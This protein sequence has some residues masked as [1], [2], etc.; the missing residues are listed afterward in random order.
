[1]IRQ[2]ISDTSRFA[3]FALSVVVIVAGYAWM[4]HRAHVQNPKNKTLPNLSQFVE[5]WQRMATGKGGI[6]FVGDVRASA[7][8]LALGVGSGVLLAFVV[9]L[10]MGCF[11]AVEALL[12][13]PISFFAK[14]P[15]TAMLAVYFVFFGVTSI[16][17]FV[18]LIGFG[19]F[20]TLAQAIAQAA[21]KDVD[22]H[23][24]SKSYTLGASSFEVVWEVVLRQILPRIIENARLQ[25]GPAMVFLI[26]AEFALA[27]VGFGYTLRMQSRLQNMNLVYT[28]LAILA[29]AG[30]AIDWVL[31]LLR[32]WLCPWFG[33]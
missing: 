2:P 4:S 13:P 5:G 12:L 28:Y 27:D 9:G 22:S 8:R 33:D 23:T 24:V 29:V 18:A 31:I 15:P 14:I 11:P 21:Q 30:L 17:I 25:I 6:D 26:A 16:Q 32:R 19:I 20:P 3:L 10:A 7:S 1:M